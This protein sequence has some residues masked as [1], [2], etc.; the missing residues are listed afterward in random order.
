MTSS[1]P[2]P[3]T[4]AVMGSC[5]TRDAFN[6][7]FN[8]DYKRFYR[9]PLLQNQSSVLAL[10]SPPV[11]V[12]VVGIE[13][14]AEYDRRNVETDLNREF[15][16][17]VVALQPDYLVLDFFGDV[18]FGCLELPD[19]RLVTDNYWKLWKTTWYAEQQAAGAFTPVKALADV[20]AYVERWTEALDRFVAH[21]REGSPR[22]RLVVHRGHYVSHKRRAGDGRLVPLNRGRRP[23]IDLARTN[24]LWSRLDDVAVER[25]GAASIDLTGERWTSYDEHPWG[26]FF[27]HYPPE[28]YHRF[29]AELHRIHLR[30]TAAPDVVEML[31]ST[32]AA[33]AEQVAAL[34]ATVGRLRAKVARLRRRPAPTPAPSLAGRVRRRLRR[35]A[36]G[37]AS[38]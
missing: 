8:P 17:Q 30:A 11:E 1:E 18:H 28:Y 29:L 10:M 32:W 25:S 4:V 37:S 27:V 2:D 3:I 6:T 14:M 20:D 15:L 13:P 9:C 12:E 16:Q 31:D 26:P 22:T 7:R 21:V 5:I 33:A 34:E 36:G 24:A 23:Q 38:R 19:G 35:Y